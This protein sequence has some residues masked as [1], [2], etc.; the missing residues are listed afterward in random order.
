MPHSD[1]VTP[2]QKPAA[3]HPKLER[4][5][6]YWQSIHPPQGLPG[7]QHIEPT[8]IP[9]LLPDLYM[10]DVLGPP[11]RFKYRLVGTEYASRMGHDLTG[12]FLDEAHPGFVQLAP[13]YVATVERK[14]PDYRNGP[15]LFTAA[16]K[17]FRRIERLM[18]PLARDG[19]HVDMIL[20]VIVYLR[21]GN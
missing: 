20:G 10:V 14:Q 19:A 18:L 7:R 11:W 21:D 16:Q 1:E 8:A 3:W 9:D 15:V 4:L 5:Y 13:H 2:W 6:A 17:D 12:R